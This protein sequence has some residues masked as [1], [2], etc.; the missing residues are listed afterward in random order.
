[1][2]HRLGAI[3]LA[4]VAAGTLAHASG[5][6]GTYDGVNKGVYVGSCGVEIVGT[7]GPYCAS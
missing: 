4:I 5:Y 2:R 6:V 7:P 3:V 1:M